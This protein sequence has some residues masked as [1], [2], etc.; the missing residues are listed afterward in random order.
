M[1]EEEKEKMQE[2]EGQNT[3]IEND[4]NASSTDVSFTDSSLSPVEEVDCIKGT[5]AVTEE[6]DGGKLLYQEAD[7]LFM[8]TLMSQKISKHSP[9]FIDDA[10]KKYNDA[11]VLLA[12]ASQKR[13]PKDD[14]FYY[15]QALVSHA[16]GSCY[17]EKNNGV[18]ASNNFTLAAKYF[19]CALKLNPYLVIE[20]LDV[21]ES[22]RCET[23][24]FYN[25]LIN[26][27]DSQSK[28]FFQCE[29]YVLAILCCENALVFCFQQKYTDIKFSLIAML[30]TALYNFGIEQKGVQTIPAQNETI[31]CAKKVSDIG[32]KLLQDGVIFNCG[33]KH[34][35]ILN[36]FQCALQINQK[37]SEAYLGLGMLSI[38][39]Q[40]KG[41]LC[42]FN[43]SSDNIIN[44]FKKALLLDPY[45]KL[46]PVTMKDIDGWKQH[47]VNF[48]RWLV[49]QASK[50]YN[51]QQPLV[52]AAYFDNVLK[53]VP[54]FCN[55]KQ[56][57]EIINKVYDV[58]FNAASTCF[59]K[60]KYEQALWYLGKIESLKPT[61]DKRTSKIS[62]NRLV[63]CSNLQ[64]AVVYKQM[65]G[66]KNDIPRLYGIVN[67]AMKKSTQASCKFFPEANNGISNMSNQCE[68]KLSSL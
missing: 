21:I 5:G 24:A 43:L 49:E 17:L 56:K 9:P 55:E 39:L 58:Y 45:I 4:S 54:N 52:A 35:I 48:V 67:D 32:Y 34:E 68:Q 18:E 44:C 12:Q 36:V 28:K 19:A 46:E 42:D 26:D 65:Y 20:D 8:S 38:L 61:L 51:A 29:D 7:E 37:S 31:E 1:L 50:Q 66:L 60:G 10:I 16:L 13:Y 6:Q 14:S 3:Y 25:G 62:A 63:Q 53:F 22:A 47:G 64:K 27:L 23:Q 40:K 30:V 59:A 33:L 11:L 2:K 41:I 57:P 15:L